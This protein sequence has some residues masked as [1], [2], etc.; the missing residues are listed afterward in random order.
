[1]LRLSDCLGVEVTNA[2]GMRTGRLEDLGVSL[3]HEH[4]E[5]RSLVV[6]TRRGRH[7]VIRWAQVDTFEPTAVSAS[8]RTCATSWP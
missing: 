7:E 1:V 4:P 3:A 6:R 8:T 2:P 5:V